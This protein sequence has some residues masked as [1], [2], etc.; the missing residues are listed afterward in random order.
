V[1]VSGKDVGEMKRAEARGTL[2]RD[3]AVPMIA[4][5]VSAMKMK[6]G[7]VPRARNMILPIAAMVLLMP[8]FLIM[9]GWENG[10]GSWLKALQKPV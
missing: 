8:A 3:G 7:A 2:L 6:A 10:G 4:D 1:I 9:T 5:D